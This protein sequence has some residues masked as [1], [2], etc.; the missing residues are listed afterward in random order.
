M[1]L[2]LDIGNTN[3]A[4]GLFEGD[5]LI[6]HW[7]IRT[8][9][10]KTCDEYGIV[11]LNLL[12]LTHLDAE[13]IKSVIISSVVPPLT[14]VFQELGQNLFKMK[15]LIVGPGLKTGMPILNEN[16]QEVGEIGWLLLWLLSRSMEGQPLW[17]ISAQRPRLMP[18]LLRENTW[19]D[20]LLLA[21]KS[22]QKPCT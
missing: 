13:S 20:P 5:N 18:F 11:L 2:V 15:P 9:R 19:E 22:L 4:L 16:P 21:F 8:E 17:S 14:P 7:K 12:S 10:D 1:L 6:Q 3:I